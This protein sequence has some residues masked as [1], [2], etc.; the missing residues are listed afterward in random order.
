MNLS[1]NDPRK[2]T[3]KD[4]RVSF[5]IVNDE[6]NGASLKDPLHVLVG[7]IIRVRAKRYKHAH[8]G[9]IH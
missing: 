9:V 6:N 4:I 1:Q 5:F 2:N 8:N 7:L 3:V